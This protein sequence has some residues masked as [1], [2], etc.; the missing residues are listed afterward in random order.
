MSSLIIGYQTF[1]YSLIGIIEWRRTR[2]GGSASPGTRNRRYAGA[3][4]R[5]AVPESSGGSREES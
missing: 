1:I 5:G 3:E 4:A 2:L